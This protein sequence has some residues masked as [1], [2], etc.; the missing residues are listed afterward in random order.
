MC[1]MCEGE[2]LYLLYLERR[3]R[4][5]K[6]ARNQSAPPNP[7]WLWLALTSCAAEARAATTQPI[8]AQSMSVA[9]AAQ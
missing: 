1:L 2:D 3:E 4:A 8:P 6:A 7:N 5:Q 9:D